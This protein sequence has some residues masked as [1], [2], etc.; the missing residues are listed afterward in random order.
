MN[1]IGVRTARSSVRIAAGFLA[2]SSVLALT[3]CDAHINRSPGGIRLNGSHVEFAV[4]KTIE[5]AEVAVFGVASREAEFEYYMRAT[6]T[7]QLR[8]GVPL[9]SGEV[10]EG[11]DASVWVDPIVLP[12]ARVNL[13]VYEADGDVAFPSEFWIPESGLSYTLWTRADGRQEEDP[14][15]G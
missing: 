5:G 6:G 8:P 12:G 10:P 3:G 15:E 2:V 9:S 14:C 4:C 11:L 1:G 7:V 13:F